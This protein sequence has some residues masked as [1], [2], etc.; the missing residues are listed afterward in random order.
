MTHSTMQ[1]FSKVR[2]WHCLA[3]FACLLVLPILSPRRLALRPP[4]R[5]SPPLTHLHPPRTP[6]ALCVFAVSPTL[7]HLL[8]PPPWFACLHLA[9]LARLPSSPSPPPPS[10]ASLPSHPPPPATLSPVSWATGPAI[11]NLC[12]LFSMNGASWVVYHFF[13]S[14]G[15]ITVFCSSRRKNQVRDVVNIVRDAEC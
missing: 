8:A 4:S 12:S 9:H 15:C 2:V 5:T 1:I 10:R 7:T 6:A 11:L 3:H 14:P 13:C